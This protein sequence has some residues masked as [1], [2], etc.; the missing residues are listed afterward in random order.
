MATTGQLIVLGVPIAY[1][2][3][4]LVVGLA[5]RGSAEQTTTEGFIAGNRGIGLVVLYFIMGASIMSA[6]AFLGG[7]GEAYSQG[8][9]AYYVLAYTG[10]G[11]VL[12]YLFG[13][14]AARLGRK[15]GYVTQAEL[16]ADRY[17]SPTLSALMAVASIG[18][19]IPYTVLQMKGV[20]YILSEASGGMLPFW[21]A[22]LIP[23]LVIVAYVLASGMMGV[24]W[25]NV[26]Q[27]V[28]MLVLAWG[29]GLYLPFELYGG[30]G[31]MFESIAARKSEFLVIGGE[32][33]GMPMLTY[34]STVVVSVLGFVMWPHL[35]MRAYT[36][37]S[38]RTLKKTIAFYP[39]FGLIMVP[40]LL[41]GFAGVL[42]A[43][44]VEPADNILPYMVTNLG[45]NPWIVGFLFAG[46]LA[47]AMSSADSIVHAAASVFT[48]DFYRRVVDPDVSDRRQ[49]QLTQ[50]AVV[51]VVAVS[52]Y[53]AVVSTMDIVD[54]L[55][56]AY[57]AVIQFLPLIFGV[58]FWPRATREGAIAGL[59]AGSAVTVLY[60]FVLPSPY[61]VH[62]GLWGLFVTTA[63]FVAVS[64]VTTVDDPEHA[65]KFVVESRPDHARRD[66]PTPSSGDAVPGDD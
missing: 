35:F 19:F 26:L 55:A 62:A 43:P 57:G 32:A 40:I 10:F 9:A 49:T 64:L 50:V 60:T 20:G 33:T 56:G 42:Y 24:G 45:L 4:A 23:F 16:V 3:V 1:L 29:L 66:A 61:G 15:F 58:F 41:I 63:L 5:G 48:R 2:V 18:A 36:A 31:P 46:G 25:S 27:G 52:Y 65:R 59:V 51:G 30:I 39:T 11:M 17:R 13:P 38:E 12:W 21:A 7:P 34:S 44:G 53:F 37:D 14:K 28:M 54:L 6:F 22:A 8:A 47:A